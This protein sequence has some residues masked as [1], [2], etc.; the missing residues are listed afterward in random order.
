MLNYDIL[1]NAIANIDSTN[2]SDSIEKI[3]NILKDMVDCLS[4]LE[5][6]IG[7]DD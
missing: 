4:E 7:S 3:K 2:P 5:A 6:N 1:Y